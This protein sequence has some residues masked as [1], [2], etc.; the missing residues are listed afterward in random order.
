MQEL[1]LQNIHRGNVEESSA[2]QRQER[3]IEV[4]SYHG[5]QEITDQRTGKDA[6]RRRQGKES[7]QLPGSLART[8]ACMS[9]KTSRA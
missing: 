6:E 9:R 1:V 3:R 4:L 8:S 2:G 5:A 7:D